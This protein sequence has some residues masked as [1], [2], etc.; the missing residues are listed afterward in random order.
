MYGIM[1]IW[2]YE[3]MITRK[4]GDTHFVSVDKEDFGILDDGWY[5]KQNDNIFYCAKSIGRYTQ[6]LHRVIM[7]LERNDDRVIDHIDG[8]GMN[9]KKQNLRICSQQ[10][11]GLN[12][13]KYETNISGYKG[14]GYHKVMGKWQA[15][16]QYKN[17]RIRIGYFETPE[18]A[19]EAYKKKA[20]ELFGEFARL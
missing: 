7:G 16:I 6:R 14:V 11:N 20:T 1:V 15:R 17:K 18:K 19:Y 4:N 13:K 10:E 12:R 5:A 8:N 2:N 3:K 9:N